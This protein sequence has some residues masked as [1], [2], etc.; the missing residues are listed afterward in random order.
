MAAGREEFALASPAVRRL[1]GGA[2]GVATL[3][4]VGLSAAAVQSTAVILS[5]IGLALIVML[6]GPVWAFAGR[7]SARSRWS[8]AVLAW[9]AFAVIVSVAVTHWPLRITFALSRAALADAARRVEAGEESRV[10][11]RIGLFTIREARAWG[12]RGDPICL[13]TEPNTAGSTG[14]VRSARDDAPCSPWSSVRLDAEWWF[15]TE[16]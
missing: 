15:I 16:D 4:A 3:T 8:A 12:G 5:S 1:L 6:V 13:W 14:F 9:S 7:A 11:R 2:V 10:P